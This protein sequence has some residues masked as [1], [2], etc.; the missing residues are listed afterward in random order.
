MQ[1]LAETLRAGTVRYPIQATHDFDEL[2]DALE[3]FGATR[4][5]GKH[6]VAFPAG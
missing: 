6:A 2:P 1:R 3:R 4:R 5:R